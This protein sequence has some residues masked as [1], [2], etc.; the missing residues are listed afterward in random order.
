MA[1]APVRIRV[2]LLLALVAVVGVLVTT[3][4]IGGYALGQSNARTGELASLQHRVSVYRQLQSE[5]MFKLYLGASALADSDPVT[6]NSTV[7]QL[8]QSYDF[9]RLQFLAQGEGTLVT[10]IQS[11]YIRFLDVM[12]SAIRLQREGAPAQAYELQRTQGKPVAD[13]LVR[14]TDELVNKAE[15]AIATLVDDN[16]KAFRSSRQAF[17]IA[18]AGGI[19]LAVALGLAISL[20]IIGPVA[21]MNRRLGEIASGD[22]SQRVNVVNRDELG[23][24][25]SKLNIMSS[26][27]GRLYQELESTSRHK[28]EFLANMSH[29]L[30]TPLNAIIGFSEVLL[31]QMF[32]S[33]NDK[34]AEYLDDILSSGRH[35]LL[36]INDVLDLSKVE[37]GMMELQLSTFSLPQL[38]RSG[39]TIV[40]ERAGR[41]DIALDLDVEPEVAEVVADE[42]KIKQVVVNLLA[43]AVKFTPDGGRVNLRAGRVGDEVHVAVVDTGIGIAPDDRV[44][45]FEEFQQA[46]QREGSGLGL[47]LARRFVHLHGGTLSVE[48]EVG[49]G[50]TF[51]FTL[52]LHRSAEP[53]TDAAFTPVGEP[54]ASGGP[55]VL[56]IED[57]EHSVELLTIS[58]EGAGFHVAVRRDGEAGLDA[59]RLLRPAAIVLDVMLPRVDGWE[60]LARAKADESIA[61]IPVVIVS[62]LDERGKGFALGA[63]DYLVKPVNRHDLEAALTALTDGRG[64]TQPLKVLVIDDDPLAVTLIEGLLQPEGFLVVRALNGEEGVRTA[65]DE[66]PTLILLDLLMPGMDGFEVLERLQADP[67]TRAIPV[68]ILTST[69]VD[70]KDRERLRSK[71][72]HLARK[73]SFN[74]SEFVELVRRYCE[75]SSAKR[76]SGSW[77]N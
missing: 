68:V 30:R 28:S 7:R 42:L 40:R 6:L 50:S 37:A 35:L 8:N 67:K 38:L 77:M 24:L 12:T 31:E 70:A 71:V 62:M 10:E 53:V 60:F 46:G 29:E 3:A 41:H 47:A 2:K 56:L 73:S 21:Q 75:R 48:S 64:G 26:E 20:S 9:E 22:F 11:A 5:T 39:V 19:V 72:A 13:T 63:A 74:K 15:S 25:A 44:R 1:R 33:L 76:E 27:L 51:T 55:M 59:A 58:L 61:G 34:Q 66:E 49:V 17:I 36:L 45:I 23:A 32:G 43:N 65:H 52:P 4:V 16:E 14:L 18:T 54:G 57:D 69:T